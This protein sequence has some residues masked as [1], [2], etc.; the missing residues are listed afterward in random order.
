[1]T[2]RNVVGSRQGERNLADRCR[3]PDDGWLRRCRRRSGTVRTRWGI[4]LQ[5]PYLGRAKRYCPCLP[6]GDCTPFIIMATGTRMLDSYFSLLVKLAAMA[7]I[8]S[9]LARS[10]SFKSMLMG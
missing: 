4:P 5:P 2:N 6:V 8:A 1:M 10:S 7:S 9:V 3:S